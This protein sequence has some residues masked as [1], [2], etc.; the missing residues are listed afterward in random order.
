MLLKE[1][2]IHSLEGCVGFLADEMI[3]AHKEATPVSIRLNPQKTNGPE[4]VFP[5]ENTGERV[6]W[7]PNAFYLNSRPSFTM[8]PLFHA[9][10]YY[11]QEASSMFIHHLIS[12]VL[13]SKTGL[14]AL[15]LCAA[16]GGKT[17]L[18]S[19]MPHFRLVL[20]NEIIQSRVP[21]LQENT[22]KWGERHVF[23][24]NNDPADF[25]KMAALFDLVLVDAPCSGSGLFRK[26][27]AAMD[28]WNPGLVSFCSARQKRILS[29]A[30]HSVVEG[31]YLLYSTCSYSKEENEDNLDHIMDSGL[32]ESIAVDVPDE[33]NV[34]QSVSAFKK[35][36][37]Y[38]FYPS[39]VRGEGFFCA[40]FQKTGTSYTSHQHVAG[41]LD[42]VKPPSVLEDWII[43][44]SQL[45][46]FKKD[47]ELFA[48][49]EI[50][51]PAIL[52]FKDALRLRRSGLRLGAEI[53]ADLIP[54]HELSMSNLLSE[55]VPVL[56]LS[57]EEAIAFLRKDTID[58][59]G[60]GKGWSL[61]R[62]K[63][64]GL[65]WVKLV[66]GRVKNHYPMSWRILKRD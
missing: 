59:E 20:A 36:N 65:G 41:K 33:W 21:V 17:T 44:S 40:L 13:Q 62:F 18:L 57:F 39:K 37:G 14:M 5:A 30:M 10:A 49:D 42:L 6:A 63:G 15:D 61:A 11:V 60:S 45:Q 4:A 35:A 55:N 24:S 43:S 46:F 1:D 54:D 50:N 3:A 58:K 32:F 31:G 7:C 16:P 48:V 19:S 51:L 28:E 25:E 47:N 27:A 29:S 56:D 53:R 66:Q 12:S 2:F 8:D 52:Q 64:I 22:I 9:G 26:D 34:V 23:V 38:R